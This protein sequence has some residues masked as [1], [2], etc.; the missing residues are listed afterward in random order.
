MDL[1]LKMNAGF[2]RLAF[3]GLLFIIAVHIFTC[4]WLI[5]AALVGDAEY[6]GT[7]LASFYKD[8]G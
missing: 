1:Y 4:F 8:Y 6:N 3:Y 5:L 7:W 2:Q